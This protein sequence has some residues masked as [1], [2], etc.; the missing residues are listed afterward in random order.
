MINKKF[1]FDVDWTTGDG[2]NV[3]LAW[4]T[5]GQCRAV[6]GINYRW[7]LKY[8]YW[9]GGQSN[10]IECE[11]YQ[12]VPHLLPPTFRMDAAYSCILQGRAEFTLDTL[13]AGPQT[14][15]EIIP[16]LGRLCEYLRR[17]T[18]EACGHRLRIKDFSPRNVAFFAAGWAPP[19]GGLSPKGPGGGLS[20]QGSGVFTHGWAC[21]DFGNWEFLPPSSGREVWHHQHDVLKRLES[22]DHWAHRSNAFACMSSWLVGRPGEHLAEQATDYLLSVINLR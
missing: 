12:R 4:I 14:T 19:G 5:K 8:A 10:Q 6:F 15:T 2:R 20:P 18:L 17:L 1:N 16:L 21:C 3:R 7:V 9:Q 22:S 13:L 11:M